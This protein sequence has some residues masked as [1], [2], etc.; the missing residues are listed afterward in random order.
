M[1]T[2]PMNDPRRKD[3]KKRSKVRSFLPSGLPNFKASIPFFGAPG[4]EVKWYGQKWWKTTREK[5]LLEDPVCVVCL[6][7]GKLT[8]STD[9]DHIEA[10]NGDWD[11]FHDRTNLWA[12]CKSCHATK[13]SYEAK[14][15]QFEERATWMEF[16]VRKRKERKE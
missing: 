1:P 12:L 16:L 8:P 15:M 4:G 3:R 10:H 7:L 5:V 11:V 6:H 14:G 2:I 13:S 9:V